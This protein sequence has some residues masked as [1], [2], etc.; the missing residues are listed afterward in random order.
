MALNVRQLG[1]ISD[2][3]MPRRLPPRI[4]R[5]TLPGQVILLSA[6]PLKKALTTRLKCSGASIGVW[7]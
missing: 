4:L 5:A 2:I 6:S 3:L 1:H 7:W